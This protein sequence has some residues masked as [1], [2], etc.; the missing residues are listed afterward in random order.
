MNAAGSMAS[1]V[2]EPMQWLTSVAGSSSTPKFALHEPRGRLLVGRDAV[3][4]VAAV[5]GPI[6]LAAI[7]GANA[8]RGHF[9]VFADAEI[10]QLPLGMLGQRLA[11]GPLDLLELVDLGP[12]AVIGAANAVG[13][14][15]LKI[16]VGHRG[17]G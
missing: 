12:F 10:D 3:V 14:P 5:F 13:E 6:D 16:R 15:G 9:V 7:D 11:L 2:F 4:G 17:S 1:A 8:F